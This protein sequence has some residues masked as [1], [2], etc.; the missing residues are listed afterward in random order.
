[1]Y[2]PTLHLLS[3]I[4]VVD[5]SLLHRDGVSVEGVGVEGFIGTEELMFIGSGA[6]EGVVSQNVGKS[7]LREKSIRKEMIGKGKLERLRG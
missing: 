7:N 3:A 6:S 5:K 1:M 2:P 4:I